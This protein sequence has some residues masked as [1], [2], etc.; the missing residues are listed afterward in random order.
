MPSGIFA[1]YSQK[2][3]MCEKV[4]LNW[5]AYSENIILVRHTVE[6]WFGNILS[7]IRTWSGCAGAVIMSATTAVVTVFVDQLQPMFN[8]NGRGVGSIDLLSAQRLST[9]RPL[10]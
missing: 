4:N 9:A 10:G 8:V 2:S 5:D 3:V 7:R 1:L 6:V